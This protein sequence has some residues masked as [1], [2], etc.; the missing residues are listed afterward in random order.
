MRDSIKEVYLWLDKCL[1]EEADSQILT[2][3]GIDY[4]TMIPQK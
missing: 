1:S 3:D 4:N 2:C